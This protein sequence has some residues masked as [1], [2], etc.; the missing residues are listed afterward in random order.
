MAKQSSS[1]KT[2]LIPQHHTNLCC[3]FKRAACGVIWQV[4]V[5]YI[6]FCT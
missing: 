1:T 5:L 2:E 3:P 4:P 6:L